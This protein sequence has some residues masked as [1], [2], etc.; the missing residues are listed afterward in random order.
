MPWPFIGQLIFLILLKDKKTKVIMNIQDLY[1]ESFLMK[2]KPNFLKVFFLFFKSIDRYIAN[3]SDHLTVVSKSLKDFY[4]NE[5]NV[6]PEKISIIENWQ[7]ENEFIDLKLRSKKELQEKYNLNFLKNQ[8]VF[9]YL[10]NI[11]PVAGVE[12]VI[13]DFKEISNNDISLIIAGSGTSKID[14]VELVQT[15]K[16]KNIYFVNVEPGLKSVVE[17][18]SIA[19]V[20]I[21]PI[22][23][24][25]SASSI[26]SKL[27]A[28][29]F[30]SKPIISS[31]DK[32][33]FT[34]SAIINSNSGWLLYDFGSWGN[35]M[36]KVS[37]IP[38]DQILEK[39][40][41]GFKFSINNFSKSE[42]LKKINNLFNRL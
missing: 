41:N 1:P 25:S 4:I 11:G 6:K 9:M 17:L 31:A 29:M 16:I 7:D 2:I 21:L 8:F 22:K 12:D 18:Q 28:Y 32:N 40:K 5:R 42:G 24:G 20:L 10:G 15:Q 36:K 19:D 13:N 34:A 23:P 27:I 14:C 39:G 26:P 3:R 33:S 37:K 30:S 35:I 38:L